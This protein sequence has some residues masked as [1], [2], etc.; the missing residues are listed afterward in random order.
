MEPFR[1][2][3]RFYNYN[4]QIELEIIGNILTLQS[5]TQNFFGEIEIGLT[6]NDQDNEPVP[7][8]FDLV[9]APINDPPVFAPIGDGSVTMIEDIEYEEVRDLFYLQ[10]RKIWLPVHLF[11][12]L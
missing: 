6:A 12:N 8:T 10:L 2:F 4:E 9:V 11:Q 1:V 7:T 5:L 3:V